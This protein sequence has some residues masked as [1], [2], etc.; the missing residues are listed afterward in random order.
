MWFAALGTYRQNRWF[1][2]LTKQL[3]RNNPEVTHLLAR[4]PFP[5]KPP[6]FVRSTLFDYHFTTSAERRL[7][8]AWWKREERGEYLPAISLKDFRSE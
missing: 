5:D 7:S 4:N 8:G 1:I 3:L 2:G 6:L